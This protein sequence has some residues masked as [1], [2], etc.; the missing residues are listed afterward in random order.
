MSSVVCT[1]F[2]GDHHYGVGAL[3]NSLYAHGFRGTL[4]A[5]YRGALPPWVIGGK[6]FGEITEFTPVDGL[7]LRFIPLATQIHFAMYKPSFM[8][9]V[10]DKHF[11]QADSGFYFDPD[12]TILCDW[13]FYEEWVEAGV[14]MCADVNASMPA[15]HPIRHAWKKICAPRGI[16]FRRD[17]DTYFNSG[18]FGLSRRDHDFLVLWKSL[19]E[20]I[21]E[22]IGSGDKMHVGERVEPFAKTDQDGFNIAAMSTPTPISAMGQDGMN[23]Q[24]GGGGYV[25]SHAI[26]GVKPWNKQFLRSVVHYAKAP[27][28]AEKDY[29]R[30]VEG[31]INLYPPIAKFFKQFSL[32]SASLL[33]RFVRTA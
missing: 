3:A 30:H 27:S 32:K 31:P 25:M 13:K 7:T 20:I 21:L 18:F 33:A 5:G 6:Q 10:L 23:F 11:P 14:A 24:Q 16:Q 22:S 2:E 8:A 15:T 4:C 1:L 19:V 17:L 28:R 29:F 9:E 12:I 26:G